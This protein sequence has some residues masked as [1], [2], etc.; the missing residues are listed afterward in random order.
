M[1]DQTSII[2]HGVIVS[3]VIVVGKWITH[4]ISKLELKF[5]GHRVVYLDER[6]TEEVSDE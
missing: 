2:G 4:R 1:M 3:V 5:N 6:K